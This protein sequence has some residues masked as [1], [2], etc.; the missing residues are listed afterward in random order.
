[1]IAICMGIQPGGGDKD[2]T[3]KTQHNMLDTRI[4]QVQETGVVQRREGLTLVLWWKWAV[5]GGFTEE[6]KFEPC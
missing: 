5:L 6:V 1:M 4:R 3:V 2:M